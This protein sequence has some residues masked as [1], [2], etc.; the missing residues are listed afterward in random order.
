MET[1][2]CLFNVHTML[3]FLIPSQSILSQIL[4]KDSVTVFVNAIMY[5]KVIDHNRQDND[6][7]NN[8]YDDHDDKGCKCNTCGDSGGRLQWIGE[9]VSSNHS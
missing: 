6:Q 7:S 5:Y 1:L 8:H 2:F 9:T 4:T 3:T